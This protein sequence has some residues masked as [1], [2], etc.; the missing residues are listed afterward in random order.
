MNL[1]LNFPNNIPSLYEP[2]INVD[3]ERTFPEDPYFQDGNNLQKL[4]NI[5]LAF[6]RRE[7]TIGYCQGFN[8]LVGKILK[9]CNEEVC[10]QKNF[11]YFNIFI[12]LIGRN[13]LGFCL[14]N[15]KSIAH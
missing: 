9:I 6:S 10:N 7:A 11:Y 3:L 1:T 15:R 13:F 14:F 4:K 12:N 2:Q 8:F 5:L